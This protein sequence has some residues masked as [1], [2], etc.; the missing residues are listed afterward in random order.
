MLSRYTVIT[1]ERRQTALLMPRNTSR[2]FSD[3]QSLAQDFKEVGD[4][5]ETKDVKIRLVSDKL[6]RENLIEKSDY[7][8]II[9]ACKNSRDRAIFAV[10]AEAGTR[11]SELLS[12]KLK[13]VKFDD[14]GAVIA[15]DGKTG[16]RSVRLLK[17]VPYLSHWVSL[18]HPQKENLESTL[19]PM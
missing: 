3:G 7:D 15:V 9:Y 11:P 4:P 19:W 14:I 8:R 12:M 6:V 18:D 17:S 2:C 10:Q 1:R 16:A 5:P 13:H